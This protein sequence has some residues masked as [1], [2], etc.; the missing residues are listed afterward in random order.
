VSTSLSCACLGRGPSVMPP[1][2][3]CLL[4]GLLL[5]T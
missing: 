1:A 3:A 2:V 4:I 5:S